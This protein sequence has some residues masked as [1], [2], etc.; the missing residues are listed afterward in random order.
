MTE[1]KNLFI[2]GDWK[3]DEYFD[4]VNNSYAIYVYNDF[5]DEHDFPCKEESERHLTYSNFKIPEFIKK[6]VKIIVKNRNR[7][8]NY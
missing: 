1:Q 4:I 8:Y 3:I 2:K 7:Y 5:K 6:E